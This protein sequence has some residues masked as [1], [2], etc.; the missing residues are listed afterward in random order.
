[1]LITEKVGPVWLVT[2]QGA[3]TP[4]TNVPAVLAKGQGGM[5]G[6]FLSPHYAKDHSVYL[7]YSEPGASPADGSSLAL[8]KAQLKIGP[9][10]ASL[11]DLKV[12]W[13]DG[14]RGEWRPVRR[15]DSLLPGRQVSVPYSW[16]SATHDAG[17]GS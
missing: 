2:Q 7:T 15:S 17:P 13:R 16:R 12:I 6:I 10:T 5:L 4:V 14:E 9:D 3:K 1:M 11:E 8:A